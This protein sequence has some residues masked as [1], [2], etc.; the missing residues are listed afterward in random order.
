M[1]Q[2]LIEKK[3]EKDLNDLPSDFF[4]LIIKR[5]LAL[6]ENP[7]PFGCRKIVGSENDWRIRVGSYRIVYEI[8]D[9]EKTIK[10]YRVKHRKDVYR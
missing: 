2:V 1:Y 6:K 8:Q 5:I 3:A 10:I 9:K 7:R 4:R